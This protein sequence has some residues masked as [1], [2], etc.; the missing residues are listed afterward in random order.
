MNYIIVSVLCATLYK[1]T[2]KW[3]LSNSIDF[4][5]DGYENICVRKFL[6]SQSEYCESATVCGNHNH[7][8]EGNAKSYEWIVIEIESILHL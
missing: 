5:C 4:D 1:S 3:N 6:K 8:L 2:H 7:I